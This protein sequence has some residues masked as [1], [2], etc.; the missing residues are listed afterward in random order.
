MTDAE[1]AIVA[2]VHEAAD[3]S[4]GINEFE[5]ASLPKN[6]KGNSERMVRRHRA[7]LIYVDKLGWLFWD[8][9]RRM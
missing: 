6:D 8:G 2:A 5:L 7:N 3:G 4:G 1:A 9:L